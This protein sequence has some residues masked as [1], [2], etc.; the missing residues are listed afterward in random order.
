VLACIGIEEAECHFVA[1]QIAAQLPVAR[2]PAFAIEIQ[3][4]GCPNDG[5]CPRTLAVREGKATVEY[6]DRG[7][8]IDFGLAGPP[9]APRIAVQEGFWLGLS[10]PQS[11]RVA[12]PG[13][14][15]FDV[16]HC[17]ISHVIDFDGSFWLP[18]GL[19]DGDAS[20]IINSEHG[21]MTL[22][23]PNVVEFRGEGGFSARL[24]RFPGPKHFWGCI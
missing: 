6:A 18:V 2:G 3:L 10:E 21:V 14:F 5:P 1:E 22:L 23:A 11:P 20:G 13:P 12:G 24:V 15:P 17:G 8:P 9:Q 16:G 7:E 4:Y 19:I